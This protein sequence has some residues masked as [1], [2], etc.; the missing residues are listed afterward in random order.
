MEQRDNCKLKKNYKKISYKS[1]KKYTA[2]PHSY[3]S[4]K[5]QERILK[6]LSYFNIEEATRRVIQISKNAIVI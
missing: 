6:T 4:S 5:S 3:L 1:K 2:K